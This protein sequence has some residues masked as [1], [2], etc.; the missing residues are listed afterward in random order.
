MVT[1]GAIAIDGEITPQSNVDFD[2]SIRQK[3]P[4]W[5]LRDLRD[6]KE[7]ARKCG[8]ELLYMYDLPANNKAL[9]WEK[10]Q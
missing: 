5:G 1:Y 6:L 8:V 4:E 10:K 2:R 7:E 9:V 3:N